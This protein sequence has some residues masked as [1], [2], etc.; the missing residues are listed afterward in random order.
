MR[1]P[2][3]VVTVGKT[4]VLGVEDV[5]RLF[6][7]IEGNTPAAVRDR[8]LLA[9]MLYTF[10]RVSAVLDLDLADY[11]QVG[12]R[13]Y[14]R[15]REKGG[16]HHEMPLNHRAVEF[17]DAYISQLNVGSP[18]QAGERVEEEEP[19]GEDS[20][21]SQPVVAAA[22]SEDPLDTP[23]RER[24]PLFRTLNRKRVGFTDRR[25]NRRE[26]LAMIKRRCRVAGLGDRFACHTL[27]ATGI[28]AYLKNGGLLEHAQ[29]MAGHAEP[30]TTKLYDR[31]QQE[32][33]QEE[34]ERIVF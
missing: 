30:K 7:H 10:G 19:G 3:H 22:S 31:R 1:G 8:A 24:V 4:P 16:R 17:I 34:V 27:R 23:V 15:L 5:R 14:V 21:S 11:Y 20:P 13:M 29:F 9:T 28:T 12:R 33:T 18:S 32:V 2:K 6:K 26:A 25:L